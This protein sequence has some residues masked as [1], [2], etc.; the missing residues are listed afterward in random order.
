[1]QKL[2]F[3]HERDF[4]DFNIGFDNFHTTH[5]SEN[6]ELTQAIYLRLKENNHIFE[7]TIK[8]AFD[9][10]KN[11][12]LPDRYVKGTCPRCKSPDQNGDNCEVCGATYT[13]TELIN[14]ISVLSGATPIQKESTHFFFN[15]L[16]F[17]PMLQ[18]WLSQGHLQAEVANKLQE[19]FAQGLEAWDISR[20]APYFGFEF[21]VR[22]I[23]IF[24]SG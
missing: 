3:L 24:T 12:F 6:K 7:K 5:S 21:S 20:D 9:P 17:E 1:M 19:W 4:A 13:P 23:N 16:H 15:L 10:E 2:R 18:D 22:L 8:Q 11:M 14:P